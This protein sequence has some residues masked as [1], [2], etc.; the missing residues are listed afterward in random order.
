ML[1]ALVT[2]LLNSIHNWEAN[3]LAKSRHFSKDIQAKYSQSYESLWLFTGSQHIQLVTIVQMSMSLVRLLMLIPAELKC[4]LKDF[5]LEQDLKWARLF[6]T[7]WFWNF[8]KPRTLQN[9]SLRLLHKYLEPRWIPCYS[10]NTLCS[11]YDTWY[12]CSMYDTWY[13]CCSFW[14]E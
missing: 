3:S 13:L 11:M 10:F 2:F 7:E 1:F 5:W 14:V 9:A 12:L 6:W 4:I 8:H